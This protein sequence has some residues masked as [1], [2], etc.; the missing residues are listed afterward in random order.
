MLSVSRSKVM[1]K[2]LYG[3]F[4][5][6]AELFHVCKTWNYIFS[7]KYLHVDGLVIFD[8]HHGVTG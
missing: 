5:W 3:S 7:P 1:L 2:P 6:S 4:V 8:E